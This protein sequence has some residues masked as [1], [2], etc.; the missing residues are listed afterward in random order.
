M[1]IIIHRIRISL[2]LIFIFTQ[3]ELYSVLN[4]PSM[5]FRDL[6]ENAV[7]QEVKAFLDQKVSEILKIFYIQ[8]IRIKD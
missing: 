7:E 1:I 4:T 6:E 3:R 5:I 8:I 2:I